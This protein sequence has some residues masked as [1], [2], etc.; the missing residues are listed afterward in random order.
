MPASAPPAAR[1]P[2]SHCRTNR[3]VFALLQLRVEYFWGAREVLLGGR[4]V[5][6]MW[7]TW[8]IAHLLARRFCVSCPPA[9]D[10]F[11]LF[12]AVFGLCAPPA[13]EHRAL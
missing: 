8:Q 13:E 5:F 11:E 7:A 6:R 9:L 10:S 12:C 2:A 4:P 1:V 3:Q